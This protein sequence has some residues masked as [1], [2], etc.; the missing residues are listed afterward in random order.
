V[1]LKSRRL[2]LISS[3]LEILAR[4]KIYL[5]AH[6]LELIDLRERLEEAKLSADLQMKAPARRAAPVVVNVI[7]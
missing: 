2:S 5:H 4:T 3:R 6:F 1:N 7:A